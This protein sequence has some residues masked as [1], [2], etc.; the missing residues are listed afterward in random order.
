[1][2]SNAGDDY[3]I[4]WA[5]RCALRLLELDSGLSLICVEGVSRDDEAVAADPDAFLGVDLT[6]YYGGT[7]ISN[8]ACVV[9]SQ[10]KYS[11]RHPDRPWTAARLC[12]KSKGVRDRSVIARLAQAF[13]G[14]YE[15]HAR[16]LVVERLQIKLVS[17]RPADQALVQA[18]EAAQCWLK[19]CQAVQTARLIAALPA[20]SREV[21]QHL[22][23]A[24]GL[25]STAF[26]DFLRCLD[27]SDCN[28]DSRLWQRLRLIQE[29]GRIAPA[30]PLEHARD[31]YGFCRIGS[32]QPVRL[33]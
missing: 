1:M 7:S 19:D 33:C 16:T 27:L 6:E 12:E 4:L 22:Q 13:S 28:S 14:S 10:L 17:N 32:Q 15:G 5:C 9:F 23:K 8:A 11:Q 24:S 20:S 3:H 29:I 30:S 25:A 31:L 18:L 26:C 21:I 2:E